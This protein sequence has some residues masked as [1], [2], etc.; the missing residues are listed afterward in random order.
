MVVIGMEGPLI[1]LG[2]GGYPSEER[3][4]GWVRPQPEHKFFRVFLLMFDCTIAQYFEFV[5][6]FL[7]AEGCWFIYTG[8]RGAKSCLLNKTCR[9]IR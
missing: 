7:G 5:I 9:G 6:V 8:R 1:Q 4:V 3:Q 2:S